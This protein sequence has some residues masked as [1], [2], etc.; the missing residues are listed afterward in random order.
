MFHVGL[1]T[2]TLFQLFSCFAAQHMATGV[3]KQ[4]VAGGGIHTTHSYTRFMREDISNM[5]T[6]MYP[7]SNNPHPL[8]G[9]WAIKLLL[10]RIPQQT[11]FEFRWRGI[12]REKTMGNFIACER[13]PLPFLVDGYWLWHGNG[14][15]IYDGTYAHFSRSSIY[16][17]DTFFYE[18]LGRRL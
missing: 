15:G 14:L 1:E 16:Y 2:Y 10:S 7:P 5:F 9:K 12:S 11:A 3:V 18:C 6:W 4:T 8:H 13:R 17:A